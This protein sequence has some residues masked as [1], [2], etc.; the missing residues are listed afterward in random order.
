MDL[1]KIKSGSTT[2]SYSS[3]LQ[4][5]KWRF[6]ESLIHLTNSCKDLTHWKR[7]WCWEGLGAGGEGDDRGWDGWMVSPTQWTFRLLLCPS[8]FCC[9]HGVPVSLQ[10]VFFSGYMPRVEMAGWHHRLDG[11]ESEWTWGVGDGQ[12]GLACCDSWGHKESD[13]TE[14][15]NWTE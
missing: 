14:R 11:H 12:G 9:E 7:P 4:I 2:H 13:T 15:L 3:N 10:T 1:L 8:M 5:R 6:K